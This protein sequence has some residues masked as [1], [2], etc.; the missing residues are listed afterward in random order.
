MIN[1]L[2]IYYCRIVFYYKI[3]HFEM[4]HINSL[5]LLRFDHPRFLINFS[6]SNRKTILRNNNELNVLESV[7]LLYDKTKTTNLNNMS[8]LGLFYVVGFYV[9]NKITFHRF[10]NSVFW[11]VFYLKKTIQKATRMLCGCHFIVV[12]SFKTKRTEKVY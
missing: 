12:L 10:R 3:A 6:F 8:F 4:H 5:F 2:E 1:V 11:L 7:S 9:S